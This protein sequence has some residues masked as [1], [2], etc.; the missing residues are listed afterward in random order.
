MK[1]T[2]IEKTKSFFYSGKNIKDT[3]K[4][5]LNNILA[6]KIVFSIL[7]KPIILHYNIIQI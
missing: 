1:R 3:Y 4:I 2:E 6:F 7:L 5:F